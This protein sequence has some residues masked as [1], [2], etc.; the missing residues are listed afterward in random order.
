MV[1]PDRV[2]WESGLVRVG[3]FRCAVGDPWFFDSGPARNY[4][5]V[6]PRTAVSIQHEDE[7][8]FVANPNI[9]TFY[10]HGQEYR[11]GAISP[12]G[13]RCDWFGVSAEVARDVVRSF[14]PGVDGRPERPFR[15]SRGVSDATT[16]LM[17]RRLF[18]R[19]AAG[20]P[21]EALAVEE[22]VIGLL[23]R[24]VASAYGVRRSGA[25]AKQEDAIREAE[26]ILSRDWDRDVHLADV[27][28][29]VGLSVYH[30][31]RTFRRVTGK[32]LH[33]YRSE[34][35]VRACLE[36]VA[37]PGA[38][39]VDVAMAAGFCSHS[40]FTNAFH[41]AFGETPSVSRE[42]GGASF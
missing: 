35:R 24:V 40:H 25:P 6:F 4:C 19:V 20:G 7:R 41:R 23:E 28:R 37:A 9:V 3:A 33:Q 21:V 42:C 30:L 26:R 1:Q 34:L 2:V 8:A 13:D 29:E 5:F 16:F 12:L 10:N 18:E 39:L 38:R 32:T 27:A 36:L 11:R 22:A 17:Q 15:F 31:C 14:D